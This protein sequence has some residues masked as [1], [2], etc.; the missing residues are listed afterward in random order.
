MRHF[1]FILLLVLVIWSWKIIH[2]PPEVAE[3]VHLSLQE[4]LK[5]VIREQVIS[6]VP[7][8]GQVKIH[9]IWTEN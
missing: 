2:R 3:W 5:N 1:Y 8:A 6:Q 4:E 7:S 9:R